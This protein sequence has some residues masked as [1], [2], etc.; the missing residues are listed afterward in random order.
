M[1]LPKTPGA[2]IWDMDGTLIDQTAGIVRCYE[3]VVSALGHLTP[4]PGEIHRSMG[5]PMAQ[6]MAL[7]VQ[8]EELEAACLDFRKR[9]PD[10]M[11][12]GI[13]VLPG[14]LQLVR[15]FYNAGVPQAILTNKH[16]PTAREVS[17]HCGFASYIPI[18]VGSTDTEWSKPDPT[19]TEYV[20][21][22]M[23]AS[24]TSGA[25]LIG[26]SPTDV[27]TAEN[28]GLECYT[29]ATGAHSTEELIAAGGAEAV[30]SLNDWI[31]LT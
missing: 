26:D 31:E 15:N 2:V 23:D 12:D 16:G 18:C 1:S 7:F 20:L 28:A 10:I 9:F 4:D 5:G 19:L 30:E 17:R 3:E 6:T 29:V 13:I 11:Y 27:A 25:V 24:R 21:K 8:P 14:A 22:A